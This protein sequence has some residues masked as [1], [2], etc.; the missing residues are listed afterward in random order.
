MCYTKKLILL[1]ILGTLII[2]IFYKSSYKEH[3]WLWNQPTRYYPSYDLRGYPYI[4][5]PIL[6]LSPYYYGSDGSYNV[7]VNK[8][9]KKHILNKS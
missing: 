2:C 9:R 1:F 4:I 3:F 8:H 7:L 5:P 6:Y